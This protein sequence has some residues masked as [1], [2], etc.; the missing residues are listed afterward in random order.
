MKTIKLKF[1]I[2]CILLLFIVLVTGGCCHNDLD[3]RIDNCLLFA[4]DNKVEL[5]KFLF[6]YKDEPLKLRAAQFLIAN[7]PYYYTYT[8]EE[9]DSIKNLLKEV[10]KVKGLI[11]DS[12][13]VKWKKVKIDRSLKCFDAHTI[14]ADLLIENIDLA[15]D[16]WKRRPWSKYYS[17]EE[18]C[19]YILPYRI[20]DEP[21]ES[22]RKLYFQKYSSI[23]DSLYQGKDVVEAAKVIVAYLKKE[24]FTNSRDFTFPHLGAV[25]LMDNRVGYC[26]ENCDIAIYVLRSLGIPVATD[27]YQMSPSYL[28][29]HYWSVLID[30]TKLPVPFNYVEEEMERGNYGFRKKGKV[31]RYCFGIQ[32]EKYEGV[33]REKTVPVLFKNPFLRD[34]TNEYTGKENTIKIPVV[35][36]SC[37]R[38]AYLAVWTGRDYEPIDIAEFGK[39]GIQFKGLEEKVLYHPVHY[40]QK[41]FIPIY[42]PFYIQNAV[43]H[44]F[45]P[46]TIKTNNQKLYRKYPM[47]NSIKE[48]IGDVQGMRLEADNRIDFKTSELLYQVTDTPKVNYNQVKIKTSAYRY[49]RIASRTNCHNQLAEIEFYK[50]TLKKERL[51]PQKIKQKID[52]RPHTEAIARLF[53]GDWVS[54]YRSVYWGEILTFDFGKPVDIQTFVYVPRNDDNFVRAGDTYELFYQNGEDG[55]KSLGKKTA[56]NHVLLYDK[57]PANALLWLKNYT[58]GKEEWPFYCENGRQVFL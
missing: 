11:E 43:A 54:Y 37:E 38:F 34:V 25:Y 50:D 41:G 22:W 13:K 32:P 26:R 19:E 29:K 42:Y 58:R 5:E 20:K 3:K 47:R 57:V 2:E 23:L 44:Y 51:I 21:L 14:T 36:Q 16:V 27:Y 15:F 48:Y 55:W 4:G 40:S 39:D 9:V 12:V 28:S 8:G 35:A 33:L 56:T 7:I 30:T 6:H 46:D 1:H 52:K 53:D 49:Y 45:I 31:Y 24:K 18:F 10:I 17:F